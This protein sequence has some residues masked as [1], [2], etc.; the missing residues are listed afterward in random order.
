MILQ[1]MS[2]G[3]DSGV[4]FPLLCQL[5]FAVVGYEFSNRFWNDE[6]GVDCVAKRI[7]CFLLDCPEDFEPVN[8]REKL[9]LKGLVF[10]YQ[11]EG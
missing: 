10:Q 9:G 6:L 11:L 5:V 1:I 3:H 8:K 2:V 4:G 7:G